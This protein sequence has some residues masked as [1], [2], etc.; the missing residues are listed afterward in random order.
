MSAI[1]LSRN[2]SGLDNRNSLL[3]HVFS[4]VASLRGNS[5]EK[6]TLALIHII[7]MAITAL[8]LLPPYIRFGRG[9]EFWV[10]NTSNKE[11]QQIDGSRGKYGADC[12]QW[13]IRSHHLGEKNPDRIDLKF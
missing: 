9:T 5:L 2:C 10:Y 11:A 12:Q 13:K 3:D 8:W 1:L 7:T 6:Q 4:I